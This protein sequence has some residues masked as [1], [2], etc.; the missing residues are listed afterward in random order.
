MTPR[1]LPTDIKYDS[2]FHW[3]VYSC[4][5]LETKLV[6]DNTFVIRLTLKN[7]TPFNIYQQFEKMGVNMV[8]VICQ[9]CDN[10]IE[11]Y[12]TYNALQPQDTII[13]CYMKK[14]IVHRETNHAIYKINH[15]HDI[16]I[17]RN[18]ISND[19]ICNTW[20]KWNCEPH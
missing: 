1:M 19:A 7:I 9:S 14:F 2:S 15:T 20:S 17:N 16:I 4:Q 13:G 18:L 6:F 11:T 12:T 5:E 10:T 8:T 3:L